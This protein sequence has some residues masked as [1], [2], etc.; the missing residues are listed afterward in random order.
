MKH[1]GTKSAL[2]VGL[3]AAATSAAVAACDGESGTMGDTGTTTA[4]TTT[5]T[6]GAGGGLP[7]GPLEPAGCDFK[8]AP[9]PEYI[10]W[11]TS[12]NDVG[13]TPNIRRVRLGLG[14]NVKTGSP[15][16]AD[17]STSAGV[18]WQTDD[19]TLASEIT[20]GSSPDPATW[21]AEN[22]VSGATW[23][24]PEGV[25]NGNGDQRMHEVYVCGLTP[26][27]TYYYRVGG[28]PAGQEVW[29]EVYH[30]TTTP[31]DPDSP[32][33]VVM[34]GDSR[35]QDNEAW[36]V[37]QKKVTS[38]GATF[39]M[40]SGDVINLAPD[41]AEW[42]QWLDLAWKDSD[43]NLSTLGQVLT[44]Y[45]HGNHENHT[46]LFYGNLVM[47]Q[48]VDAYP[49][50]AELFYSVDVGPVHVIV[51]DDFFIGSPSGDPDYEGVL[52]SWLE[53]D[54]SAADAN[55]AKVPWIITLHHHGELSSS[56]HGDDADVLRGREYFMPLWDKYHVDL[57]VAGHDHN[58]ERSKPV[59]GP[60]DSPTV[61][62]PGQGTL[63]LVC[64]GV[65]ADPYSSGTS[66]F[67]EIS[68]DFKSSGAIGFYSILKASKSTLELTG[69]ELWSDGTDPV[70]D[71]VTLTK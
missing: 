56:S 70:I 42:E 8:V 64:A 15:G 31:S 25:L 46:S 62:E 48:D 11:S 22:R 34:S 28:G 43:G 44:L 54:L 27:T 52:T 37:L 12:R 30:F 57:S 58:Y 9:R 16:R 33:T 2:A 17:P 23:L 21:P 51:L 47:P 69:Y 68:K 41:Q 60:A 7:D 67:T 32:V 55:R 61:V 19:G 36:R 49:Q 24:T 66:S 4:S 65:G 50:Y 40:F 29:S 39:Q 5:G 53:A 26:E 45:T 59:T 71:T 18:A 63:Y 3:L 38:V 14:G 1:L 35:G 13:A 6:G 20:W 10:D